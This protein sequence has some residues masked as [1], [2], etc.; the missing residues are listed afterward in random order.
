MKQKILTLEELK[1]QKRGTWIYV[2]DKE[3]P[4]ASKQWRIK[5]FN[6]SH[7]H[8]EGA[9]D[10]QVL[11][12]YATYGEVWEATLLEC[13]NNDEMVEYDNEI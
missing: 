6:I 1:R 3:V 8:L 4:G 12:S 7:C 9:N 13:E 2:S 5:A 10:S 11:Y